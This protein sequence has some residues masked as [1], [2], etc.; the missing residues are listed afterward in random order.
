MDAVIQLSKHLLHHSN[1]A[2]QVFLSFLISLISFKFICCFTGKVKL[3]CEKAS[4]PPGPRPLP[5]IGSAHFIF[6]DGPISKSIPYN[7]K[8]FKSNF[9]WPTNRNTGNYSNQVASSV[10]R[11]LHC[12]AGPSWSSQHF[13]TRV[14]WIKLIFLFFWTHHFPRAQ[15]TTSL[16]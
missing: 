4:K 10:R 1:F 15:I 14:H 12:Q 16:F 2:E 8:S 13:I 6:L 7:F 9:T 3:R 11:H 5:L